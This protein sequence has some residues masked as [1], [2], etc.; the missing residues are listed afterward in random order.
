MGLLC[1]P[2]ALEG[3]TST[4]PAIVDQVQQQVQTDYTPYSVTVTTIVIDYRSDIQPGLKCTV[5][6][7]GYVIARIDPYDGLGVLTCYLSEV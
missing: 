4:I 7:V 3:N 1:E 6:G 5:R 2:I